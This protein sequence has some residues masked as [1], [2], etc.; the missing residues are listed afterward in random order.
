M[1]IL[2]LVPLG[3]GAGADS[4]Q[5]DFVAGSGRARASLFE[6][7]PR[8]GGL[9]IPVNFG[10]ALVT[11]QGLSAT[12]TSGGV[13]P[14]SQNSADGDCGGGPQPPG[15]GGGGGGAPAPPSPGGGK[16][17]STSF[18][19]VSTL[20]VSS[21]DKD[22]A[23]GRKMDQGAFPAGSPVSGAL[24]HQEVAADDN[25]SARAAT[26]SGR[27]GFGPV[28]EVVNGRTE[29]STG[30]VQGKA[31]LAH[32]A[33]TMDRLS[34][35]DGLI[36]LTDVRWE[37]TQRTG[38][39]ERAEGAFTVGSVL[40][41]GKPLPG[42]PGPLDGLPGMP[43]L[44]DPLAA[45]NTALAPSGLALV[46]PHFDAAAGAAQVTPL[47]LR[48]ADSTLGRVV[49]GPIV[50]DLQPLRDPVV[51]GL[52]AMSCDFGTAV[53]VADVGASIL[54]GSGGL[55]FD[56][57]GVSATTEGEHY[58][59]PLSGGLGDTGDLNDGNVGGGDLPELGPEPA[60]STALSGG[61]VTDTGFATGS[62]SDLGAQGGD[63][64]SGPSTSGPRSRSGL[65]SAPTGDEAAFATPTGLFGSTSR[66]LPGHKGGRAVAVAALALLSV[67]A[68]AAA[69]A[70]HLRR[71]SRSIS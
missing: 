36:V 69:D 15:G 26:T 71:A 52:L 17:P 31:R 46:T 47:S 9:T 45:L 67:A 8:T 3:T 57:G 60:P 58:D 44:P 32:A 23:Q 14:P 37:A 29:A 56:F 62:G 49:L 65:G 55:S 2:A 28:A 22:A 68:L 27:L 66:H 30:V 4:P 70:F 53:T 33:T 20:T 1:A 34:L 48:V 54:T 24:E 10:K 35:L 43:A 63:T 61:P 18:P 38:D 50:G 12:A 21:G 13:K 6:I 41:E 51:G 64:S 42:P 39:A 7:L 11:Y 25:P 40:F 19:F 16:G 5:D 59:N